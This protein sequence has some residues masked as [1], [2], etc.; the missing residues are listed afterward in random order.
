MKPLSFSQISLYQTCPL[1][2]RLQ[3]IDGLK[4]KARWYFSFGSTIHRCAE[5]FFRVK[6]PPP[7][8]LEELLRFYEENW[9][10][11]GYESPEEE[12][13]YKAYG[14]E[15][16]TAFWEIHGRDFLMPLAV[17]KLFYIDIGG[18][19]LRGFIDRVDK[20]ESGAL[21]IVDYKTNKELFTIDYLEK[22]LQLTLYQLAA[23]QLWQL[24]VEKLTLYH[25]RSN[26]PI[27]CPGRGQLQLNDA[28]ELVLDVADKINEQIFPATENDYCPCD[29]PEHCPYYRHLYIGETA[30]TA[31]EETPPSISGEQV[32]RYVS[33]QA[34]IK[35]LQEELEVLRQE[36]IDYCKAEEVNRVYGPENQITYQLAEMTGF[37]EDDV[38]ALLEPENLWERVIGFDQSRLKQLLND[39]AV[40]KDIRDRI[41]S[42]RQVISTSQRL[43]VKKRRDEG[44]E[45]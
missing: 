2:Y 33:I 19:K 28:K 31:L 35:A 34:Q 21:S 11:E 27:S 15:L 24:P 1:C 25:M 17:E 13:N 45:T 23:E 38:R 12:A 8:I 9:R 20:L 16:L 6:V 40:A 37:N 10:S 32:E 43:L 5:Y 30:E 39:E 3:Y 44:K 42:L 18:V 36:I 14:R 22:D 29:F 4:P 7:P 41:K 26:T